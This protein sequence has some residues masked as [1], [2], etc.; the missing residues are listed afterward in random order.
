M[1]KYHYQNSTPETSELSPPYQHPD[2]LHRQPTLP[3]EVDRRLRRGTLSRHVRP[4]HAAVDDEVGP[5]DEAAFVACE[6]EDGLGLLD[7]FAEAASGEVDFAAVALGGVVAEPVLEEGGA[8]EKET[9]L[10]QVVRDQNRWG[11]PRGLTL[12]E[13]DTAR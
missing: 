5:V 4:R 12:M 1:H 10:S 7:G 6:E 9:W 13:R 8:G 11:M 3:T 2:L